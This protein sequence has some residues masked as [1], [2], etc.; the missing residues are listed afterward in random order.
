MRYVRAFLLLCLFAF[1]TAVFAQDYPRA[2]VF[3]GYSFVNIDTN[4]L[5]SRQ[6][7]N[8]WEAS[9]SGNFNKQYAIEGDVSGYY[10]TYSLD[11]TSL[12][13]GTVNVKVDDYSFLAGPRW[14]MRPVFFHA[15]L[16]GDHLTGSALGFS[17][18]QNSFAGA[19]GGGVQSRV[20]GNWSVRASADYVFSRHNIFGGRSY[21]QNNFRVGA[22]I[23]YSF[24]GVA[25]EAQSPAPATS[26]ASMPIPSLGLRAGTRDNGAE[27]LAIEP[28]GVAALAG[29]H[30]TDVI[31]KVDGKPISTAMELAAELSN[32]APGSQ[33]RLGY[34]FRSSALGYFQ[35]ETV[36]ILGPLGK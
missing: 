21:T 1:G 23:V 19:F 29:L 30:V 28:G 9:V 14:N 20:S 7:L 16:G 34:M 24:G 5:T 35:K 27:V 25:K 8:G 13:L 15:L 4:G 11:L 2:E 6:N 32:H 17:R 18:S 36:V 22:G 10:K 33:V 26:T 3:G 12:G 31:N